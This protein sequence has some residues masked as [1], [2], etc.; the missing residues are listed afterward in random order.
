MY[1]DTC[2]GGNV[3]LIPINGLHYIFGIHAFWQ[4]FF[5]DLITDN[6]LKD[7]VG[8]HVLQVESEL[9][10][11]FHHENEINIIVNRGA[12]SAIIIDEL[13][14]GHLRERERGKKNFNILQLK[15]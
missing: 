4:Y 3:G 8:V 2:C 9:P 10:G 15:M 12:D 6:I 14:F 13:L 7:K 1:Y 5:T 11:I